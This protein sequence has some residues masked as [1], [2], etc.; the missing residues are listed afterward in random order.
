MM[1]ALPASATVAVIGAG[2]MGAGIAQVAA[3]AGHPVLL[4]DAAEGAVEGGLAGIDKFLGRSVDKG[5]IDAGERD[6]IRGRITACTALEDL[7]PAKFVIEAIIEDLDIKQDLFGKLE[8]ITGDDTIL[9]SNTS[10]LSITA[11]GRALA[12][13]AQFAGMHFFNPAPIMALV[14]VISG[15]ETSVKTADIVFETSAAW[16]KAPVR[17]KSTPG[18]IVNRC[19]RGFYSEAQRILWEGGAD[20]PTIDAVLKEAGGFR[21]GP[22]ELMD[23]IGA[24]VNLAVS[25]SVWNAY[26][27]D[28]RYTP[29]LLQTE[30]V[31]AGRLG[32][33]SGRGW[34]DYAEGAE[35]PFPQTAPEGPRPSKVRIVGDMGPGEP[36]A[37]MIEDAGIKLTRDKDPEE[38]GAV[39]VEAGGTKAILMLTHGATATERAHWEDKENLVHF[40]LTLDFEKAGR[41]AIAPADQTAPAAVEVAAGLFQ[42][43]GKAVSVIDD[44][45]GMIVMRTVAMLVNE[46][47]DAVNQGVCDAA[48][49]DTAM[50][51]GVNYPR[52]PLAWAD[53]VSPAWMLVVTDGLYGHYGE[54]RYRPSPLLRR[55]VFAGANFHD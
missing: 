21:M 1:T 37:G 30:Q 20:I 3:T 48:A 10:S 29:S 31:A 33:K 14:E 19:A 32:R 43:L 22:F 23:L 7:A 40:D 13:P 18:F 41:I 34:Y 6:A 54:D 50:M 8:A 52:G 38:L 26:F 36:L 4:Y 5:K 42:A 27:R 45:P 11:I 55:K 17:A 35:K 44:V 24:D 16:G 25:H 9:A 12:R 49:V 46:A 2:T 53:F 15:L 51:K 39:H 47:A 28:P